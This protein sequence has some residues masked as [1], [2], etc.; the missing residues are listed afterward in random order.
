MK[1][2]TKNHK[3]RIFVIYRHN[4]HEVDNIESL[5][6]ELMNLIVKFA[7]HGVIHGDFNEF[8]IMIR[9]DDEKPM[10]IDF[11]QMVSTTHINAEVYF[12]RDV[13]CIRD[14]FKRRFGYESE[15]FAAFGDI[16]LV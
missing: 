5:Y 10:I 6:D 1:H 4:V 9:N 7:N 16:R 14:F 13:N 3:L 12:Q 2:L 11:P 8:N 15:L